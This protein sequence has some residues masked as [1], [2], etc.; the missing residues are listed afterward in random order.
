MNV[1]AWG[2]GGSICLV[3]P[4]FAGCSALL[5]KYKKL[6]SEKEHFKLFAGSETSSGA[7]AYEAL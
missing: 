4:R 3:L 1:F 7:E 6:V 2:F 5:Q